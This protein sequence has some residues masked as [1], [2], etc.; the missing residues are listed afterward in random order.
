M[1]ERA[2]SYNALKQDIAKLITAATGKIVKD[3]DE[4]AHEKLIQA[5]I[6]DLEK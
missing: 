5:A 2:A 3:L 6:Q 4:K 1:G